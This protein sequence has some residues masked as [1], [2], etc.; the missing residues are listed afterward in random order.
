MQ[1]DQLF[2]DLR[3]TGVRNLV[4]AGVPEKVA[5]LISSYKACSVFV[6]RTGAARWAEKVPRAL[7]ESDSESPFLAGMGIERLS[8]AG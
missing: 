5:M 3:L 7:I 6:F 2:H 4:L 8:V 1:I